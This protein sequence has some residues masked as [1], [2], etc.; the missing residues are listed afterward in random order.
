MTHYHNKYKKINSNEKKKTWWLD[1]S[2]FCNLEQKTLN[3]HAK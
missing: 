2:R 1:D 3:K